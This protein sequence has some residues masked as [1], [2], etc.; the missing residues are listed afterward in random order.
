MGIHR[1]YRSREGTRERGAL[2]AAPERE[3]ESRT[4]REN[5]GRVGGFTLVSAPGAHSPLLLALNLLQPLH[6]SLQGPQ[7]VPQ[8][9][10]GGGPQKRVREDV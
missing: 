2:R 7:D 8:G 5:T 4:L 6:E 1:T 9:P 10:Q 3:G